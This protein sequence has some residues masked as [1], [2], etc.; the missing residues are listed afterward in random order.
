MTNTTN[1]EGRFNLFYQLMFSLDKAFM[2]RQGLGVRDRDNWGERFFTIF[3]RKYSGLA[4]Q[5]TA[6]YTTATALLHHFAQGCR[7]EELASSLEGNP[8]AFLRTVLMVLEVRWK[9]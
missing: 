5:G 7:G 6:V 3:E 9:E 4:G 1:P 8:E 2:A